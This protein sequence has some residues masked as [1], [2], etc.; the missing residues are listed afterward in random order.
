MPWPIDGPPRSWKRGFLKPGLQCCDERLCLFVSNRV[1]LVAAV[2][3][4]LSFV[5]VEFGNPL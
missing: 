2:A 3:V 5:F 4:D 1:A